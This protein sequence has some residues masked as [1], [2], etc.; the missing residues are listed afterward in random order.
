MNANV[1]GKDIWWDPEKQ[2]F[3][4]KRLD[5]ERIPLIFRC[6]LCGAVVVP[7]P[8]RHPSTQEITDRWEIH[9]HNKK[10]L[11]AYF[12]RDKPLQKEFSAWYKRIRTE[13]EDE[14]LKN[15]YMEYF[16][17]PL[18]LRLNKIFYGKYVC[19]KCVKSHPTHYALKIEQVR[20]EY[21][22]LEDK[23]II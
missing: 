11:D 8:E 16:E 9:K 20:V 21:E 10:V 3:R 17:E 22:A 14:F 23:E 19:R 18:T 1:V 7:P 13:H 6:P 5:L 12:E 15:V 2:V 4:K